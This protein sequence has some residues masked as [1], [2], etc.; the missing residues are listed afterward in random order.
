[1][2]IDWVRVLKDEG[3]ETNLY[4]IK[5]S[6]KS[7][8]TML[9]GIDAGQGTDKLYGI[10]DNMSDIGPDDRKKFK[11][12]ID[13]VEGLK[14]KKAV[15]ALANLSDD[16]KKYVSGFL[17][18]YGKDI[19]YKYNVDAEKK[20][21]SKYNEIAGENGIQFHQL[22]SKWKNVVASTYHQYGGGGVSKQSLYKQIARGDRDA[23]LANLDDW[24][25]A[26]GGK[27]SD[28]ADSINN[29]YQRYYNELTKSPLL[30]PTTQ[31]DVLINDM[32][33][34]D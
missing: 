2:S 19:Q 28:L 11:C 6:E 8:V 13:K 1:M 27:G 18:V 26:T 29:R 20:I 31:E 9:G 32:L 23:A 12:V 3:Y 17:R 33:K 25:D 10:I 34:K 22:D 16:D 15:E 4:D 5:G 14:G 21:A 7:G 30:I 24:G